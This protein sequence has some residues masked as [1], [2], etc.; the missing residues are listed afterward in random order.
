[1]REIGVVDKNLIVYDKI[2]PKVSL[3][4]NKDKFIIKGNNNKQ[5]VSLIFILDDNK[6]Y[7]KLE[8][9][10]DNKD[11]VINYFVTTNYLV[12]NSNSIA[13]MNNREVYNYGDNGKYAPDNIIFSNNLISRITRNDAIYCLDLDKSKKVINICSDSGLY[14]IYPNIIISNNFYSVIKENV[15]SGSIIFVDI[16]DNNIMELPIV[17]DYIKGKGLKIGG[18][19]SLL[20]ENI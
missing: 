5:M 16:T 7:D 20:S 9:F 8:K 13:S 10:I 17:I 11:V 15:S 12:N 18:L 3:E 2:K 14:T 1:M 6:Y 19:S 4:D